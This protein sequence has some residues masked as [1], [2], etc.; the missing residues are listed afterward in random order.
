MLNKTIIVE[1]SI[2]YKRQYQYSQKLVNIQGRNRS[3]LKAENEDTETMLSFKYP[4]KIHEVIRPQKN[5]MN[6]RKQK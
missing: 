2:Y 6:S 4:W 1:I 3:I 5:S